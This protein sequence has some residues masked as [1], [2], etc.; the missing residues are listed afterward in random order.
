MVLTEWF[1]CCCCLVVVFAV[2]SSHNVDAVD[3]V[4]PHSPK[5]CQQTFVSYHPSKWEHEW[6]EK[7]ETW[8]TSDASWSRGCR[9]MRKNESLSRMWIETISQRKKLSKPGGVPDR[10]I[11]S[12]YVYKSTCPPYETSES[13]IE[14][15]VGFLRHPFVVCNSDT[16]NLIFDTGYLMIPF[17]TEVKF[18]GKAFYF[19]AGA[20]TYAANMKWFIEEFA[21]YGIH[22]YRILAWETFVYRPRKYWSKVPDNI[23]PKLSYY[24]IPIQQD[25]SS[26][27]NI[28]NYI[29]ALTTPEDYVMVKIDIDNLKIE[30]ALID[31]IISSPDL[32]GL[33][34]EIFWEHHVLKSPMQHR[35]WGRLLHSSPDINTTLADSYKLFSKLRELGMRAHSWI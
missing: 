32:I 3:A 7:I 26:G 13:Y 22:F 19:D 18:T 15:L 35:G 1:F 23:K 2:G 20:S 10:S 33:I 4:P 25:P 6:A 8:Q 30:R 28:L 31:Q 5:T 14:P 24:N 16:F 12:H 11:F 34:D 27:D 21:T 17:P 29:R 9:Q